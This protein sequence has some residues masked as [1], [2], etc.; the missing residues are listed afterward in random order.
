MTTY[1][2]SK[3]RTSGVLLG[4]IALVATTPRKVPVLCRVPNAVSNPSATSAP[5]A[6]SKTSRV[7]LDR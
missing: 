6:P 4:R 5:G 1:E 2:K 7:A 3:L